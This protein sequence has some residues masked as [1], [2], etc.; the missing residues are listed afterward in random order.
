MNGG[1][2]QSNTAT[3]RNS[4]KSLLLL[5]ETK[6]P[7]PEAENIQA[8]RKDIISPSCTLLEYYTPKTI[9]IQVFLGKITIFVNYAYF[10]CQ[11]HY[12]NLQNLA[13]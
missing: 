11:H 13:E 5:T 12:V 3:K 8:A 2:L 1:H 10:L 6:K 7:F 9:E 4:Y